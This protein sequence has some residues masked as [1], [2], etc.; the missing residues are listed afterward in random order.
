MQSSSSDLEF[1]AKKKTTRR[2]RFLAEIEAVTPWAALIAEIEP[3]YPKGGG[4]GRP[5]MPLE[6]MLRM[7][8]A[9]QC[10]GLSDEGF[11]DALYDSQS[12]RG[13]VGVDLGRE[14]AP[15][16]TTLL[17]VRHLLEAHELTTRIFEAIKGHLADKGL[18]LREGSIVDATIIAVPPSMKNADKS[19]DP[20][21][22]RPRKASNGTSG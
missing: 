4:R 20:E 18:L 1:A 16:A 22:I 13:F 11:E 17:N 5:P 10:L 15:D 19:R 12:V 6:R 9:Q 8:V 21:I 7:Y 3:F 14:G 2:D